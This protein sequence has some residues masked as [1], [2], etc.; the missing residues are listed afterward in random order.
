[1]E[2]LGG[3][4]FDF[5]VEFSAE[6]IVHYDTLE[7]CNEFER[8]EIVLEKDEGCAEVLN[9]TDLDEQFDEEN[10]CSFDIYE[11]R[12]HIP[13]SYRWSSQAALCVHQM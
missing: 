10:V 13:Y 3:D 9:S 11:G 1:M 6:D 4:V 5:L 12:Q 7:K 8:M 2:E